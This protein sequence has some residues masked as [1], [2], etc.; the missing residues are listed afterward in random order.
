MHD[1]ILQFQIIKDIFNILI[2]IFINIFQKTAGL[3]QYYS[4]EMDFDKKDGK[5]NFT[6]LFFLQYIF[7]K[8]ISF[9]IRKELNGWESLPQIFNLHNI[10]LKVT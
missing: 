5:F 7:T 2:S 9:N 10:M 3:V 6:Y 4:N 1:L 8:V